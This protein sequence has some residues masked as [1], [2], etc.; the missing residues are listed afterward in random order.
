MDQSG[1]LDL[2]EFWNV[3]TELGLGL[4]DDEINEWQTFADTDQSGTVRS[5]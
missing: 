5:I 2:N 4:S 1:E 3:I